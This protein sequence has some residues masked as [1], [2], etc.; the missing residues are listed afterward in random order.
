MAVGGVTTTAPKAVSCHIDSCSSL[1]CLCRRGITE[2]QY[3]LWAVIW[4]FN[5][6]ES[7]GEDM[8]KSL[9]GLVTDA[10]KVAA[11]PVEIAAGAARVVT[12]PLA[13][14]AEE[15]AED[16]RNATDDEDGKG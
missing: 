11:A 15:I 7:G 8:F 3:C 10:V 13:E 1:C 9:A 12:K 4:D 5:D 6:C 16:V 14:V 2:A